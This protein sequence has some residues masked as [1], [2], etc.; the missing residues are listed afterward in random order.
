LSPRKQNAGE[1]PL[2]VFRRHLGPILIALFAAAA[3][4]TT[5]LPEI[6]GPGLTCDEPYHVVQGQRLVTALGEQGIAFFAPANIRE[7]FP[8]DNVDAPVQAP[9]GQWILGMAQCIIAARFAPAI[10][11]GLLALLVGSWTLRR[12]GRLA[13]TVAAAGVVLVP[14]M[15][16]HAHFAALDML[17]ALFFVA[18]VFAVSEAGNR[19][20]RWWHFALAGV[21]WGLAMLVR[22]H[23]VLAAAPV[24]VWLVWRWRRQAIV[25]LVA[26]LTA[27]T[28]T[29]FAGWPWLWLA[30]VTNLRQYVASGADRDPVNVFYFG[31]VWADCKTPW[32]YPWV[33]F[34]LALP[35]GLLALGLLGVWAKRRCWRDEPDLTLAA[36]T[37]LFVLLVFSVP[38]TPVYDG[39]RLF[40]MAF[41]LWA[42]WVGIGAKWMVEHPALAAVPHRLRVLL[43]ALFLLLQGTGTVIYHPCQLSHYNLL[44]GGL[45]GAERLGFEVSYWGDAVNEPLL[46]Q[47]VARSE[48]K[49]VLF[50]PNLA[51]L[52][53]AASIEALSPALSRSEVSLE[54]WRAGESD[55]GDYRCAVIYHR[56]ADPA[57]GDWILANGR[58]MEEHTYAIQ[59]VWL[60]RLVELRVSP[61]RPDAE[62]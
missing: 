42:V 6:N 16:A 43:L 36:G 59:G 51:P 41:P 47:A 46:E 18:A 61:R 15:F 3:T 29:L 11:F 1:A 27:G 31:Q 12:E 57:A 21:V 50:G 5:L 25:P 17:T 45:W 62:H 53:Q 30:P 39:V 58:V 8:W 4:I 37:L 55:S 28:A 56:R 35:L 49:P 32:H 34:F 33:M 19:G 10:A 52:W 14:R 24:I 9:L 22:L 48:G 20:G 40:L 13:G 26:W 38:G 7:N 23:G 2:G 60:A 54:G 44:V